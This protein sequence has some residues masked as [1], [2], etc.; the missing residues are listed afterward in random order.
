MRVGVLV[1]SETG[2]TA[3]VI[4]RIKN[5]MAEHHEVMV[6]KLGSDPERKTVTGV[7]PTLKGFDHLIIAGPVQAFTPTIPLQM[8]IE[9]LHDFSGL[10]VDIVMTQYFRWAALGGNR[11]LRIIA[12]MITARGG[13]V[14]YQALVHWSSRKREEQIIAAV[15]KIGTLEK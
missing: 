1:Y 6:W 15:E 12:S 14:G 7:P 10:Q 13:N 3:S 11:S 2:H 5:K 9:Q 4:E 8:A